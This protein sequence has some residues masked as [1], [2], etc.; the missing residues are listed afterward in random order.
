MDEIKK[1]KLMIK[2]PGK[3]AYVAEV[4]DTI[5]KMQEIVDGLIDCTEMPGVE[6]VDIF[7]DDE[8]LIKEKPG[9][10]WLAGTENCIEGTIYFVGFDE[11]TGDSISLTDKQIKQCEKYANTFA[12]PEGM[13]LYTDYY[14][15]D[16]IMQ[17]RSKKYF[18]HLDMEN[19]L[20]KLR[21]KD[22]R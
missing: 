13:N 10:V 8:G 12:L 21:K 2:E 1:I 15:L 22:I 19:E 7:F 20:W 17:D 14:L 11:E 3:P 9:N 18:R 4:D 6:D 16:A 5:E